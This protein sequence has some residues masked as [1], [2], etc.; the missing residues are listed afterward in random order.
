[1]QCGYIF[2]PPKPTQINSDTTDLITRWNRSI[3]ACASVPRANIKEVS[4]LYNDTRG[5]PSL[6]DLSAIQV[7]PK[8]YA[9]ELEY[10][11]WGV[12]NP[13]VGWSVSNIQLLWGIVDKKPL[14]NMGKSLDSSTKASIPASS[15]VEPC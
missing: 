1:M 13:G 12:E 15:S 8:T 11:L 5:D 6:A 2:S 9:S 14:L 7:Q 10:P 3:Q 4:F